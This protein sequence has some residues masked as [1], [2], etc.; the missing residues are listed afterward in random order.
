ML[1]TSNVIL[2]SKPSASIKVTT[3]ESTL[4]GTTCYLKL[5][6]STIKSAAFNS[7]GVCL[8]K[9]IKNAGSYVVQASNGSSTKSETVSVS[10][11]DISSGNTLNVSISLSAP[12]PVADIGDVIQIGGYNCMCV[13]TNRY[14][15]MPQITAN[16]QLNWL[17]ASNAVTNWAVP[18]EITDLYNVS[19]K[20][21][22]SKT[23][24]EALTSTQRQL[25]MNN[26]PYGIWTS[27][28]Y[29]SSAGT[30]YYIADANNISYAPGSGTYYFMGAI[31][32]F[33]I[34]QK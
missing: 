20:T 33:T 16:L 28:Q 7:T 11:S 26:Y 9:H 6:S 4:I 27:T 21:M 32:V 23:E 12:L 19:N 34:S 22:I 13:G 15:Y 10:A 3:Q 29:G 18:A 2:Q 1:G 14:L 31:P 24:A 5:N 25:L 17:D 8:F 30:Y